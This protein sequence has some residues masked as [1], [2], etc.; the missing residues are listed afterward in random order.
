MPNVAHTKNQILLRVGVWRTTWGVHVDSP[1]SSSFSSLLASLLSRRS[2][3]SISALIR[4]DSFASSLRQ[5]A[6]M[7]SKVIPAWAGTACLNRF[8]VR[9]LTRSEKKKKIPVCARKCFQFQFYPNLMWGRMWPPLT[10]AKCCQMLT[11]FR[12]GK[13]E[14]I[15]DNAAWSSTFGRSYMCKYSYLGLNYPMNCYYLMLSIR[16][17]VLDSWHFQKK[18]AQI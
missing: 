11:A 6:I 9:R 5:Q 12:S 16:A 1:S 15:T 18:W 13:P 10:D 14:Q 4:L 7:E 17:N 2:C 8:A 3:F